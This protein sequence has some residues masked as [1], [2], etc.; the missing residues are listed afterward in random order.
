MFALQTETRLLSS[1]PNVNIGS[2]TYLQNWNTIVRADEFDN[3]LKTVECYAA[4]Y[5]VEQNGV[6]TYNELFQ[7]ASS[8]PCQSSSFYFN[9]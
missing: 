4:N 5:N 9:D 2:L 1:N 7:L 8:I 6:A 3:V